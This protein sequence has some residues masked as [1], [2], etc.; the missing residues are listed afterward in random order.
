MSL[1]YSLRTPYVRHV[2][3]ESHSDYDT[4]GYTVNFHQPVLDYLDVK[5][6]HLHGAP[7]HTPWSDEVGSRHYK[8]N[9]TLNQHNAV[10]TLKVEHEIEDRTEDI[11][12]DLHLKHRTPFDELPIYDP[13]HVT[14]HTHPDKVSEQAQKRIRYLNQRQLENQ[15]KEDTQQIIERI[16]KLELRNNELPRE[17]ERQVRGIYSRVLPP[18]EPTQVEVF[19]AIADRTSRATSRVRS[20]TPEGP[21]RMPY[22]PYMQLID[23]RRTSKLFKQ[24]T[25]SLKESK[26]IL[27]KMDGKIECDFYKCSLNDRCWL[28]RKLMR[29]NSRLH[30]HH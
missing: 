28:C 12:T 5:T 3:C 24:V 15:I 23:D 11:I 6:Q 1:T 25:S 18:V 26:R 22:A 29:N 4:P 16:S 19:D 17:V 10:K 8:S 2:R 20:G 13:S 21:Q 7:S 14:R 30:Y 9:T 27:R